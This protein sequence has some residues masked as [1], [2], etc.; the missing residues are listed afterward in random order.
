MSLGTVLT[1]MV[2]PYT[3]TGEVDYDKAQKLTEYLLTHGS[4]AVV[5]CG[6]TGESPTLTVPEKDK[7]WAA[8]I[9]AAKGKGKV[10]AGTTDNETAFSVDLAKR[11]EK[12]GADGLLAVVPYY[13]K[14]PQEGLYQ[15]FTNIAKGADIPVILYNIPGRTGINMQPET[16]KRIVDTCPNVVALKDST[17]NLDQVSK[18][19]KLMGPDFTIYSGD[20]SLTLPILSVGGS[21]VVSV[22]SHLIGEQLQ[23]MIQAFFAGDVK[24]ALDLHLK[25]LPV[26]HKIFIT[27]NPIPI[28]TCMNLLGWDMGECRLPLIPANEEQKAVLRD[29]LKEADLLK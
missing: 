29:M 16:V 1:A 15:H 11:A 7:L 9:E 21:G 4:D 26:F 17:G 22:A 20:D 13:N 24:K 28:K 27:A 10:I 5:V 12:A 19:R 25:Y 18:L 14:P 3:K 8:V 2:T 23:E 6:T